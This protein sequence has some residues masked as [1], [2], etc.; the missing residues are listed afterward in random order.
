MKKLLL[1]ACLL[2]ACSFAQKNTLQTS[3][4]TPPDA[5]KPRVWWHWMNG[6]ITKEG[7]TKDLEWMKRVGIGGFQNFDASLFTPNVTPRKLVFMTPEWKDAF[8]HTT[9]LATRLGLEMAIAGSPGWSVT[10]GPWVPAS[11]A[12]KKYVW[13]ETQVTGGKAFTGKLPSP[14]PTTSKFQNVPLPPSDGLTGPVGELPTYYADAAV[15]AYKLPESEKTL[16][17]LAPKVTSS[18][19]TF[20]LAQL[21]DGDLGKTTLLPPMEIGQDMWIQYEFASP[22]TFKALT[23]VGASSGGALAEFTGAP[24]NRALKVSDDGIHFKDVAQI[25]GSTVPQNTVSFA[26]VTGKYFR[27]TFK[28]LPPPAN[29]FGAMFGASAQPAG[30][31]GVEVAEI[32]LFNTDRIDQFEEKAGFSP[33]KEGTPYFKSGDTDA[34]QLANVLDL[35]SKMAA[36]GTL[37]WT[38]PAGTWTVLRLGYSI[39]GRK[40]HPASPEATGLEVDKL[41]KTA[42]R[43]YMDTYLDMYKDATGGQMGTKG[44]QYMVLDSY[45]AGHMTWTKAMPEEFR[46][47]RGYDLLPWIPVL[48][49]RI[50]KSPA[51][52]EQ[53]LWDFRKTIGEMIVENHYEEIGNALKARGMKRYTESHENGRIYLAD[54]MDVKRRADIPM[55]AMWTPGSLAGGNDEEVRSEADIRES[56]S[57]AHIYGQ[58][59]VAA[60]SMTSVGNGF[61]WYPEK[62]KRTADLEMASGL[63]RFVIHTS[64]HQPLDDKKPGFSLGPF[65]QYFTRQETWA[66]P[67]KAW[68][69][70][71]GRSCYL[72]QQGKPV[73]DVLYYYGENNNITQAFAQHLPPVPEGYAF[74]FANATVIKEAL[75][76]KNGLITTPGGQQY[77]L[78]VLDSTA[79]TMTLPVLKKLG[80]LVHA[81][82]KVAGTKPERSPSLS[83]D[84]AAFKKLAD[85]IW[86]SPQVSTGAPETVLAALKIRQDVAVTGAKARIMYVHRQMPEADI[87]WL[88]NRSGDPNEA[89]ISFRVTGKTPMLWNP[90]TGTMQGVSYRM[91]NGRTSIPVKFDAWQAYFIVFDKKTATT[92]HTE[93]V[94]TEKELTTVAGNWTIRFPDSLGAPAQTVLPVLAP[95]SEN[96]EAGIR[97]FSGTATYENT[98]NVPAVDKNVQYWL[99][100]GDVKNLAEVIVNGKNVGITWKKPYRINITGAL[101]AGSNALQ[102]KVTN[103]WVNRLIGDAQPGVVDK[104]TFTTLPFYQPGSPLLP[105][106]LLGPVR[107]LAA[108]RSP[109][110]AR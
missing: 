11:D 65:G 73:V 80:E 95:L 76:V 21:T 28:T 2:P 50:V 6:N 90:E 99:D 32:N 108:T 48:T 68:M 18:G 83:D 71:L 13:T 37:D 10:G 105:S 27:V 74:D 61:S 35:T 81:G 22:Q 4:L 47:R 97:Y 15:I 55:G 54:G 78:L 60:E 42:V 69:E 14:Q 49:G 25:K 91:Q 62:L 1:F 38:P 109:A 31:E 58:N 7:I 89:E 29:P 46:K 82:M 103:T 98:M 56:A 53:F 75:S 20:N 34:V 96:K 43:K 85:Q 93:P 39:T 16:D 86:A 77:R 64:V 8:R 33:W 52:S 23:I 51:A 17:M 30:P 67:G 57:V 36:D 88:D 12:M 66:E 24:N 44:L 107:V 59:L 19:G 5:A 102:V 100:L 92:A 41:D 63:N 101:K 104:I 84:A 3:F 79:S 106:G 45:E 72:L 110:P 87:Y 70:Y 9:E 26:P 40:N 94:V